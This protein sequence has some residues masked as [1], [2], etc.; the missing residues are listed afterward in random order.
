M[1][2][3]VS[4]AATSTLTSELQGEIGGENHSAGSD[5]LRSLCSE[6]KLRFIWKELQCLGNINCAWIRLLSGCLKMHGSYFYNTAEIR[7]QGSHM[8]N[9]LARS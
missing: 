8:S 6:E 9:L 2:T 7:T 5:Q 4:P 1:A 3:T